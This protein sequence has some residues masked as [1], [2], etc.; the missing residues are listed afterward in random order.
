[1]INLNFE[2]ATLSKLKK[3]TIIPDDIA[4]RKCYRKE[5]FR[6]VKDTL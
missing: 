6:N 1:M 2:L 4:E 3:V 5:A